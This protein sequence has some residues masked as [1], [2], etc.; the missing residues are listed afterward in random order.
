MHGDR[1]LIHKNDSACSYA[2]EFG[3]T[4]Q[5]QVMEILWNV[6]KEKHIIQLQFGN[7]E[8]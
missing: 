4:E 1:I 3:K 7:Q 5:I 6:R 8:L 2:P